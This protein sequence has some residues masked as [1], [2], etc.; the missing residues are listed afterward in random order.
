MATLTPTEDVTLKQTAF[1]GFCVKG[2]KEGKAFYTAPGGKVDRDALFALY[3]RWDEEEEPITV[4]FEL[5]RDLAKRLDRHE[6]DRQLGQARGAAICAALVRALFQHA[7]HSHED[8]DVSRLVFESEKLF[9]G[10]PSGI[11]NTVIAY[12]PV[13]A[14]G[15]GKV[16]TPEQAEASAVME[17]AE[18]FSFF[19]FYKK[20]KIAVLI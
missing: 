4:R 1:G 5:S 9:H 8:A 2:L 13:W 7:G 10:T 6:C 17:L 19:S 20:N 18:R 3:E 15:T 12:E 14:I 16:A 11:D